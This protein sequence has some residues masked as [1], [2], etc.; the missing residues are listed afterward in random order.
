MFCGIM[1]VLEGGV[2]MFV[3]PDDI[4]GFFFEE[5]H[6]KGKYNVVVD[7]NRARIYPRDEER[8]YKP[9]IDVKDLGD[10]D[11]AL[12]EYARCLEEFYKKYP[13][14]QYYHDLSYFYNNLLFNMVN[15]DAEDLT[16]YIYR[17]CEFLQDE[18]F[19]EYEARTLLA[20]VD[21]AKYYG[22]RI[23]EE[24]GLE[25][26][27]VMIFEV[28]YEGVTYPLPLIRYAVDNNRNC[29]L[30]TIQY[31]R[32]R[33]YDTDNTIFKSLVNKINTGVKHFRNVSPSFVV[34]F[35]LFLKLL[36]EEDIHDVLVPGFLFGRYKHYYRANT[37]TRSNEIL[38]R[39]IDKFVVLIQRMDNEIDGFDVVC[40]LEE[41][42]GFTHIKING[43]E[44]ENKMMRRLLER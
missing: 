8:Y 37:V 12:R 41:I 4:V 19:A 1:E 14:Y 24:P 28:E 13:T 10:L 17:R 5:I 11:L 25:T 15:S 34:S 27:F 39:I 21:G 9:L 22:Q 38:K 16:S 26:P 44:A 36:R 18:S 42:D 20:E 31:G 3:L 35:T 29:H 7:G 6:I 43:L 2:L 32:G 40:Y 30:F 33:E 23:P